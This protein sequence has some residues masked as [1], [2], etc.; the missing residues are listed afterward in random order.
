[1]EFDLFEENE[2]LPV[3]DEEL[4]SETDQRSI[5]R[6]CER[7]ER[8]CWCQY[9]PNPP[10]KLHRS[11]VIILQHPNERKKAI[12]TAKMLEQGLNSEDCHI[13]VRRK[14]IS[15]EISDKLSSE[16]KSLRTWMTHPGAHVLFP[17]AQ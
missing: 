13:F 11:K 17:K 4:V 1:M 16:E 5:C 3:L 6:N 10:L 12:R 8:V 14:V 2:D 9:L 15:L 7:P